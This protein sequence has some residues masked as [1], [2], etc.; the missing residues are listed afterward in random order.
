MKFSVFSSIEK[1][2]NKQNKTKKKKPHLTS[3]V[4]LVVGESPT[5]HPQ[6]LWGVLSDPAGTSQTPAPRGGAGREM[7]FGLGRFVITHD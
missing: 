3:K 2:K 7:A 4:S 5:P 1:T 6:T